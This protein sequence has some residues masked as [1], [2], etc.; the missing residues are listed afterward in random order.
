MK[1][2]LRGCICAFDMNAY[3]GKEDFLYFWKHDEEEDIHAVSASGTRPS[4]LWTVKDTCAPNS[5]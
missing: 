2:D 4:L 3:F 5:I 1:Y